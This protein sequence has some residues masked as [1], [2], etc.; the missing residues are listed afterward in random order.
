MPLGPGLAWPCQVDG[1]L[2]RRTRVE[3][4]VKVIAA[5]FP[6]LAV[7]VEKAERVGGARGYLVHRSACVLAVPGVAGQIGLGAA[8]LLRRAGAA[9]VLPLRLGGQHA[10]EP[11]GTQGGVVPRDVHDRVIIHGRRQVAS[12]VEQ[13]VEGVRDRHGADREAGQR[14]LVRRRLTLEVRDPAGGTA[15]GETAAA[16]HPHL[17][18]DMHRVAL[19][20]AGQKPVADDLVDSVLAARRGDDR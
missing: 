10:A 1:V 17:R 9:G 15:H 13:R 18:L 16:D 7:E 2:G 5:P 4:H 6:Y 14:H 3:R 12:G 11:G 19:A 8:P 20:R